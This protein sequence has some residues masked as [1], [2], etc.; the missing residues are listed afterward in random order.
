M[1][2]VITYPS[3][4]EYWLQEKGI[5]FHFRFYA[6][7]SGA[8]NKDILRSSFHRGDLLQQLEELNFSKPVHVLVSD[9]TSRNA[10]ES[11]VFH[12][13]PKALPANCFLKI[14]DG[15]YIC[16]PEY[17][18]V[19]S[20]QHL[21][22]PELVLLANDLCA[23]YI[24]DNEE[25]YFQRKREPV[26]TIRK[27]RNFLS[28]AKNLRGVQRAKIALK[29]VTERSNSPM[30]SRLAVLARLPLSRGGYGLPPLKLNPKVKL[31]KQAADLL[32]RDYCMCDM[33][34]EDQKLILEYDSTLSHL[35]KEQHILDKER[36]TALTMSNYQVLIATSE[37]VKNFGNV[38]TLFLNVRRKL[39][40]KTRQDRMDKYY[41]LR[42]EIVHQLIL[43]DRQ[44]PPLN[45]TLCEVYNSSQI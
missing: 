41:D 32:G 2:T 7:S 30:E 24:K 12:M 11:V 23:I 15:L 35:K 43:A 21:S 8:K 6:E 10:M 17:C 31:Y 33:V 18:F 45:N 3:A 26:T 22:L 25:E 39:Q 5:P 16:T 13:M 20:A 28:Q 34:W 29:Y 14:S 4:M 40:I 38:E 1:A 36:L 42:R 37:Q 19:Q 27:L 44:R 9:R